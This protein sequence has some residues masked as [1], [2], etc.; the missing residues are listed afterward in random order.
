MIYLDNAAT[1]YPKPPGVSE[2]VKKYLD[3]YGVSSGRSAYPAAV[4]TSKILFKCRGNLARFFNIPESSRLVFTLNATYGINAALKGFLN[5]GDR[6]ITSSVEHNA[7]MRPLHFLQKTK[8]IKITKIK[9]D[10]EGYLNIKDF[11][12]SL[13]KCTPQLVLINHA[14]NVSGA[15]QD[16]KLLGNLCSKKKIPFMVDAAQT[17]GNVPIDVI[18]DHIDIMAFS[19]HK[20]LLG[21]TGIGALYVKAGLEFPP[22]CHG[23]TGSKSEKEF[24]PG[25]WPDKMESGTLNICPIIGLNA[26]LKYFASNGFSNM[27]AKKK[28]MTGYL[29]KSLKNLNTVTI[30]GPKKNNNRTSVVSI[31]V[32][33]IFPSRISTRLSAENICVRVGLH[34]APGAHK[35]L[36]TFPEGTV[37]ITPGYFTKKSHIDKLIQVLQ[38]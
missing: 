16:I 23:G 9:C 38:K 21:P 12:K 37:R 8:N 3:K 15:V 29:L 7:V 36:G 1:S 34:C 33:N 28:K 22:L 19:G 14:S 5:P 11:K 32:K 2:A 27:R 26:A 17:A 30:H 10:S 35:T 31:T 6:V 13:K 18:N 20:S 4:K 24:Q 25:F